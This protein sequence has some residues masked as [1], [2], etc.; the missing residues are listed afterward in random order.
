MPKVQPNVV[1]DVKPPHLAPV[2]SD[3]QRASSKRLK[4]LVGTLLILGLAKVV[5]L[6][7]TS[8]GVSPA[9]AELNRR[10]NLVQPELDQIT[11]ELDKATQANDLKLADELIARREKIIQD[12]VPKKSTSRSAH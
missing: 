7:R 2:Q 1:H 11:A 9:V 8:D 6:Q 10:A 3:G 12:L 4:I 5:Q